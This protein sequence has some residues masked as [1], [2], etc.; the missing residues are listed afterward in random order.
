MMNRRD[1]LKAGV[2]AVP[3][4]ALVGDAASA[5][6]YPRVVWLAECRPIEVE[7]SGWKNAIDYA[8]SQRNRGRKI[9]HILERAFEPTIVVVEQRCDSDAQAI[10]FLARFNR[11]CIGHA[12]G[13]IEEFG[14]V[15]GISMVGAGQVLDVLKFVDLKTHDRIESLGRQIGRMRFE[16]DQ[17][18]TRINEL[19]TEP[20]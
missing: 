1:M 7:D 13:Y 4:S 12:P 16:M 5:E 19:P 15:W 9:L 6:Q 17:M 10:S 2:V 11:D 14:D 20:C 8:E 3:A 18:R